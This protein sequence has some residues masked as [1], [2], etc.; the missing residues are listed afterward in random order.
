MTT[1]IA[2]VL[3]IVASCC[4]ILVSIAVLKMVVTS[5]VASG[6]AREGTHG[7]AAE[8]VTARRLQIAL[9][10]ID[11]LANNSKVML[12]EFSDFEC[13]FC[14]QYARE[15][16]PRIRREFIDRGRIGYAFASFPLDP[17]HPP[18]MRAAQAA[19]CASKQGKFWE[20]HDLLFDNRKKSAF[21]TVLSGASELGLDTTR[22]QACFESVT[23]E[24]RNSIELGRRLDVTATP[25][26]FLGNIAADGSVALKSRLSG[27]LPYGAFEAAFEELFK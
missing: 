1:R 18:A 10:E 17:S 22:F 15:T 27:A 23:A 24:V 5:D 6:P 8:D 7:S 4:V 26:F 14:G 21:E 12:I 20:M 11:V 13:R 3:D 9:D 2:R 16:L 25:T 19:K